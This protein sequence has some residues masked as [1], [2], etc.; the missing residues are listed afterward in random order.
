[1][2]CIS[3]TT[4]SIRRFTRTPTNYFKRLLEEAC[5]NHAYLARHKLKDY[6]IMQSFMTLRSLTWGTKPS[7][8]HDKSDSASFP[9]ENTI[10][11][12]FEGRSLVGW[13]PGS[14]LG[15]RIPTHG[16]WGHGG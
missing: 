15:P 13:H 16:D 4:R 3:A 10:M 1:M 11:M 2:G 7:E 6:G 14:S 12:V 8:G 5:P 9:E